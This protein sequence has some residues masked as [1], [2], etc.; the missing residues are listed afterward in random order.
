VDDTEGETET[1]VKKSTADHDEPP[2]QSQ[3]RKGGK[4]SPVE[5]VGGGRSGFFGQ[6]K[7]KLNRGN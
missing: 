1:S 7:E 5:G 3:K 6:N 2:P 4:D